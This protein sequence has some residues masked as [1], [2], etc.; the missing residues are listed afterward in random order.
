MEELSRHSVWTIGDNEPY[1]FDETDYTVPVHA[2]RAGLPYVELEVR[3]DVL[4]DEHLGVG[5]ILAK[6]LEL[7]RAP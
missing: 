2:C 3:Q 4:V 5:A 7:A 6:A 1:R